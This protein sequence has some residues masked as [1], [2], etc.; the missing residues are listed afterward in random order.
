MLKEVSV[1]AEIRLVLEQEDT[2]RA[3]LVGSQVSEAL[4]GS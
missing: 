4:D 1:T 3:S 2:V